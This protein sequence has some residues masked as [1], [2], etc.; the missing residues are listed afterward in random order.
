VKRTVAG[1]YYV[2]E[3]D[4]TLEA[5]RERLCRIARSCVIRRIAGSIPTIAGSP[6]KG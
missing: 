6:V 1:V 2:R 5:F 3:I 4:E